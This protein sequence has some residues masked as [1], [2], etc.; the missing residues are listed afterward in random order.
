MDRGVVAGELLVFFPD[1]DRGGETES[2]PGDVVAIVTSSGCSCRQLP[3]QS[4]I[5]VSCDGGTEELAEKVRGALLAERPESYVTRP[6]GD[7]NKA[8]LVS[9][10]GMTC[11]SCVKLIERSLP[12]QQ[13]GV[14]GVRVS[15]K[16]M[17]AFVE[18]EASSTTAGDIS[19]TI[20]DMGFD[21]EV[22]TSFPT[23][24]SSLPA[25]LEVTE[26]EK[27]E[28]TTV[29]LGVKGMVCHSCVKN[30]QTNIGEKEEVKEVV[31]SLENAT[32]TITFSSSVTVEEL[33]T[34]IED[35]GFDAA[36]QQWEG[37]EVE[38]KKKGNDQKEKATW[39]Q[40]SPRATSPEGVSPERVK[41]KG[42]AN[43]TAVSHLS[44]SMLSVAS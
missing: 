21:T 31:V 1:V 7:N 41:V 34:A 30:I 20:Y 14:R 35:L 37:T 32:A 23:D 38:G 8:V 6:L 27:E 25:V 18:Y 19:T 3:G 2:P 10:E 9:V 16:R 12:E 36:P 39:M 5:A 4:L 33:C 17:E 42:R 22:K 13:R 44:T 15:L 43:W 40:G 24:T 29:V 26:K 11:N 28:V